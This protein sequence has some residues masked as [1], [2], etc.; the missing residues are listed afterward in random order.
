ML[1][2]EKLLNY[3]GYVTPFIYGSAAKRLF[4]WLDAN[5]T[6]E[7]K[8]ALA[9]TMSLK[10][11][12]SEQIAL[13]L[14]EVFDR[15][16]TKPLLGWRAITRSILF[17]VLVS[18]AFIFEMERLRPG[19][20]TGAPIDAEGWYYLASAFGVSAAA[21][22][23]SLFAIRRA[24]NASGVRPV[25]G[26]T[27]GAAIGIII[28][29]LGNAV[30]AVALLLGTAIWESELEISRRDVIAALTSLTELMVPAMAVFAWV[31]LLA[32]G[33]LVV[34]TM[35]PLSRLFAKTR[36]V[37]KDGS[38]H[39]LKIIGYIAALVVFALAFGWQTIF[40]T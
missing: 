25:L 12:G 13:A 35:R 24:L 31:P 23:F 27:V 28:V 37:L 2:M 14:V 40:R 10:D 3:F 38:D 36:R 29:L 18:S 21:D 16:Y 9:S 26:L 15:I 32:V 11:I 34:R 39:P 22:Y 19:Y 1:L 20:I 7:A 4:F 17:T 8:A 6:D 30:R 33:I 5:L